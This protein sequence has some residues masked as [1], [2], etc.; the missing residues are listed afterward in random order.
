MN[1]ARTAIIIIE[2]KLDEIKYFNT[3]YSNLYCHETREYKVE[4]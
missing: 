1:T 4:S 2:Y 3:Y